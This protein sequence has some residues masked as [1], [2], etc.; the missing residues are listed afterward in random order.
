ML[1]LVNPLGVNATWAFEQGSG[2]LVGV[3]DGSDVPGLPCRAYG[4]SAGAAL[5]CPQAEPCR[6]CGDL[7]RNVNESTPPCE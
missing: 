4:T 2:A 3:S 6:L 7:E 5:D 1:E